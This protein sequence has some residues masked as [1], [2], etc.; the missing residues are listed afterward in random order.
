MNVIVIS[1]VLIL[2]PGSYCIICDSIPRNVT[3]SKQN[4][5]MNK[6]QIIL[7]GNPKGYVPEQK[8]KGRIQTHVS[9]YLSFIICLF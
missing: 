5:E 1:L 3:K 2:I 8:Y 9:Y 7:Q 6:Y 4:N